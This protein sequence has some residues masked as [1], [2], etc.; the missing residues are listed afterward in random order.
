MKP[1]KLLVAR[2][3]LDGL[4]SI[5]AGNSPMIIL[6]G[7]TESSLSVPCAASTGS[8]IYFCFPGFPLV[9]FTFDQE[10]K[11]M[12]CGPGST[13]PFRKVPGS[14]ALGTGGFEAFG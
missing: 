2:R 8:Q 10:L 7:G 5:T 3:I 6:F 4:G 1:R 12:G 14:K 9:P 11:A 13:A